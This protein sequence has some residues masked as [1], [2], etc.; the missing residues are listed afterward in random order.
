MLPAVPARSK[1]ARNLA[2]LNDSK[3]LNYSIRKELSCFIHEHAHYS[4]AS[5]SVEEIDELNI[6][7]ASLLAM[8]RAVSDLITK[9][10]YKPE[11]ILIL[12]D[13]NKKIPGSDHEQICIIKGDSQ[14]ASI[15]AASVIAKVFRDEWMEKTFIG[16]PSLSLA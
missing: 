2:R 9:L 14:S 5:A 16:I 15:A 6:L 8:K 4:I 11:N 12:I 13:G 3:K 1:L 10:V 7:Q